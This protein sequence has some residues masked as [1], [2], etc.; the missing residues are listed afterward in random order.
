MHLGGRGAWR[1]TS[2]GSAVQCIR[3][4]DLRNA[5]YPGAM[6]RAVR[7]IRDGG[8]CNVMHP[9]CGPQ[10]RTI[11]NEGECSIIHPGGRGSIVQ[12]ILEGRGAS[13]PHSIQIRNRKSNTYPFGV[14]S[15]EFLCSDEQG[16]SQLV[17]AFLQPIRITIIII[18]SS[19][20][21]LSSP[22]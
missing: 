13:C 22:E 20:S 15:F 12:Y 16:N 14:F 21:S 8:E 11:G 17:S 5:L 7:S 1:N 2:G 4:G 6:R 10:S 19:S 3:K 9:G 18:L